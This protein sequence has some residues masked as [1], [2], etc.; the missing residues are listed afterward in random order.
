MWKQQQINPIASAALGVYTDED[1]GL[2]IDKAV[3]V[4]RVA[5]LTLENGGRFIVAASG[6]SY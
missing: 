2:M 6:V 4:R 5:G 1:D 3:K